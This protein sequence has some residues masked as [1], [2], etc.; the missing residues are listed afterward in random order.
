MKLRAALVAVLL[1]V[2]AR[3]EAAGGVP[4]RR[5]AL[6]VAANDGGPAR[7]PL[8]YAERDALALS[9]LLEQLGGVDRADTQRL[10]QPRAHDVTA[11]FEALAARVRAAEREGIRTEVVFYYSGHS[12]DTALLLGPDRLEYRALRRLLEEL[13]TQVRIAILDSCASGAFTRE[14]GGV[15]RPPFMVDASTEVRGHAFLTSSSADEAAQES[16]RIGGSFFTHYLVSGLRGAADTSGDRKITLTEAYRF[17]FEETLARTARTQYGSQHPAYEIR[18]AGTGDLVMTD[19]R[20]TQAELVLEESVAGRVFV[21]DGQH[22]LLAEVD[23]LTGRRVIL[24]LPPGSYRVELAHGARFLASDARPLTGATSSLSQSSFHEIPR[25]ATLARGVVEQFVEQP[26]AASLIPP[27]HTNGRLRK[28]LP[29]PV[30]N[31]VDVAL[32]YDDPDLVS[33]LQLGLF[34]LSARR[35]I[36]GLQLGLFFNDTAE[37]LGLQLGGVTN[38]A[39]SFGAGAQLT[40]GASYAGLTLH[41]LQGSGLANYTGTLYGGQ[42][43]L[44]VNVVRERMYGLQLGSFNLAACAEGLQLGALNLVRALRGLQLGALNIA[45]GRVRG[46]QIGLVNYADEAD[47]SLALLGVTRKGGTHLQVSLSEMSAP[48]LSLRL[49]ANY[50][51]SFVSVAVAPYG[52]GSAGYAVGAGLGAKVPLFLP[53]L[54]LDIDLGAHMLQSFGHYRSGV[55]NSLVRLRAMARYELYP[56]L[57]V[58]GGVS[59]NVVTQ[60]SSDKRYLP[61]VLVATHIATHDGARVRVL[62]WPGF[63][64]GL[65]L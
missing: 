58:F 55:P 34:G 46:V 25:E 45:T 35:Y 9:T 38:V 28:R 26:F 44:G 36:K 53:K 54:W 5:F 2:C 24:A 6:T 42:L 4:L 30:L 59:F 13:P 21:W 18:L 22:K 49:D 20:S 19:L 60:A 52:T 61:D 29:R 37:L 8:Q 27:I 17:A 47:V 56:H 32:L 16:D 43:A 57:S 64:A 33:G 48:E 62:Y 23:K 11:A 31:H 10:V 12:D 40:L 65:R 14:K 51:Y 7:E 15:R 63:V 39:R 41:G 50:N 3:V 1:L